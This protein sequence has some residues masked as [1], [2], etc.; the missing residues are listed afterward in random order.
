M[1]MDSLNFHPVPLCPILLRFADRTPLK[2][3]ERSQSSHRS[4]FL[5]TGVQRG[6]SK[7]VKDGRR[8][9]TLWAGHP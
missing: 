8:P 3:G 4:C 6:V 5:T 1:A 9:A 2:G 7:Q